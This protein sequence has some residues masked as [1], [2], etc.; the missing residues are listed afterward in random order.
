MSNIFIIGE[1][2]LG[3][4]SYGKVYLGKN[5]NHKNVAIK[6]CDIENNGIY[7]ESLSSLFKCCH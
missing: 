2:Q 7:E 1:K 5:D 4:G 6:C 3:S